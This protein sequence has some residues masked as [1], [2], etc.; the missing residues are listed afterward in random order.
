MKRQYFLNQKAGLRKSS[1]HGKELF[2]KEEICKGEI[3]H[4]T[5]GK[6]LSNEKIEK[7][8]RKFRGFSY[9]ISESH[10][11]CPRN[12]NKITP[13]WYINH[14]CNPNAGATKNLYT[15]VAMRRIR[16]G[17]AITYDYA[18]TDSYFHWSMI[19]HCRS[20]NCRKLITG[21]DWKILKLQ[22]KYKGFFQKNIQDKIDAEFP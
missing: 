7:L 3:I 8:P 14:S 4:V 11:L 10:S 9:S 16:K 2:A 13:D 1:I 19:C 21:N 18:M 22:K 17:E 12:F 6:I 15:L 5:N 20:R